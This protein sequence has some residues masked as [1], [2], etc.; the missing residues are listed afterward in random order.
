MSKDSPT[1]YHTRT[2]DL[3]LKS[4]FEGYSALNEAAD[5]MFSAN[6]LENH[7][8]FVPSFIHDIE[9]YLAKAKIAT[10]TSGDLPRREQ[11]NIINTRSQE[12]TRGQKHPKEAI[13]M[14]DFDDWHDCS[15]NGKN[16]NPERRR[17]LAQRFLSW[18]IPTKPREGSAPDAEEHPFRHLNLT[19]SQSSF[20]SSNSSSPM[21][22][23][24]IQSIFNGKMDGEPTRKLM[25]SAMADM[26]IKPRL[27][28][29]QNMG[30]W[31]NSANEA[32]YNKQYVDNFRKYRDKFNDKFTSL[33]INEDRL[34]A[35]IK[36]RKENG[37]Y[38]SDENARNLLVNSQLK[39]HFFQ[40]KIWELRGVPDD[41][42]WDNLY[43]E[44]GR[45]EQENTKRLKAKSESRDSAKYRSGFWMMYFGI[46]LID[47]E[48]KIKFSEW[49]L[50]G[51]GHIDGVNYEM[52]NPRFDDKEI[53]RILGHNARGFLT[54]HT[55]V[56]ANALH[57]IYSG[58]VGT[59]GFNSLPGGT[60]GQTRG[61]Q[62][63][64]R[65]K[66]F[67]QKLLKIGVANENLQDEDVIA[68]IDEAGITREMQND[69]LASLPSST[70]E[71][72]TLLDDIGEGEDTP[73]Y[74]T[75][76][77]EKD[78]KQVMNQF[79]Q[80]YGKKGST[81]DNKEFL[82]N[83]KH[84]YKLKDHFFDPLKGVPE[85]DKTLLYYMSH[86]IANL[87]GAYGE[88]WSHFDDAVNEAF[89]SVFVT[90]EEPMID[91]EMRERVLPS[92]KNTV[93]SLG[94]SY[95]KPTLFQD[96]FQSKPDD[97]AHTNI[98]QDLIAA[99]R[100]AEMS[101]AEQD[102]LL[103]QY[104]EGKSVRVP[105]PQ[106]VGRNPTATQAEDVDEEEYM[107]DKLPEMGLVEYV[108]GYQQTSS[109]VTAGHAGLITPLLSH[110]ENQRNPNH[111]S[112]DY[113]HHWVRDL[114]NENRPSDSILAM[115]HAR[116]ISNTLGGVSK[117][118]AKK[119]ADGGTLRRVGDS[120][121]GRDVRGIERHSPSKGVMGKKKQSVHSSEV[122]K[123]D[124]YNRM[125]MMH[126]LLFQAHH[127]IDNYS[128]EDHSTH[129][130]KQTMPHTVYKTK[131][132]DP[133][134]RGE[135][136][137]EIYQNELLSATK[138]DNPFNAKIAV[139][140]KDE[141]EAAMKRFHED[142]GVLRLPDTLKDNIDSR[143]ELE[144]ELMATN[145]DGGSFHQSSN[146]S[147]VS[148]LGFAERNRLRND[149]MEKPNFTGYYGEGKQY[150][151]APNP[152]SHYQD[153]LSD[154]RRYARIEHKHGR[155]ESAVNFEKLATE[156]ARHV[157]DEVGEM[158][159]ITEDELRKN[160]LDDAQE[161]HAQ[162][163]AA[164]QIM[165]P[166]LKWANPDMFQTHTPK[167]AN[168]A[169]ADTKMLAH[170]CETWM[171]TLNPEERKNWIKNAR[172]Q[173]SRDGGQSE[174]VM[175][176]LKSHFE[177]QDM[178]PAAIESRINRITKDVTMPLQ[179]Q[180]WQG[181]DIRRNIE[182]DDDDKSVMSMMQ[183]YVNGELDSS[184]YPPHE[185]NELVKKIFDEVSRV[186]PK[187]A[188]PQDFAD[189]LHARYIPHRAKGREKDEEGKMIDTGGQNLMQELPIDSVK[190]FGLGDGQ[191]A[192]NYKLAKGGHHHEAELDEYTP[193]MSG[194]EGIKIAGRPKVAGNV[195]Y[196]MYSEIHALNKVYRALL[197]QSKGSANAIEAVPHKTAPLKKDTSDKGFENLTE[198]FGNF[199]ERLKGDVKGVTNEA[200]KINTQFEPV[201]TGGVGVNEIQLPAVHTCPKANRTF[202]HVIRPSRRIATHGLRENRLIVHDDNGDY[203]QGE[204]NMRMRMDPYALREF[205]P[206]L[207]QYDISAD[208][209][210]LYPPVAMQPSGIPGES[211]NSNFPVFN[212]MGS[213]QM[214]NRSD[215]ELLDSLTDDT[216]I[217]KKDGR[218]VPVKSMHRIFDYS[219]LK[220]LRGFSGDWVAS[221]IPKG[222]P[223]IL[224][225]KGKRVKAYNADMKL[226]E[227]TEDID[228]EMSKVNEKDFVVH[229]V[230]DGDMLYFI[231]LLEAADEKTHN[232][233]AKD[234]VRH[235][236]AHFES[237]EH[238]KMPEP[239]NTK[240]AD[241]EGLE[242]AIHLLRE[243]S[244]CDILL[245]DASA[246]YMRGE[247]RHPKWI[248]LSK[249][250]KIDVIILDRKGM[251]YRIGVGPIMHPEHYGSRSVELNGQHYMDVGSAKGPR[252]YDKGEYISVFCTGA[253]KAG[254]ENPTYKLRSARVD[255]DAH[256]QAADS[257]ESLS[258]MCSDSKIPHKVR[259]NKGAI[260]ILFPSLDDEV[261]YKV[262]RE[263]GG[264]MLEPQRTLWGHGEDY[265]IKLSEDMRPHWSPIA[266][267]LL[268]KDQEKAVNTPK[269]YKSKKV[270]PEAPAGHTKERK[271]ILPKEEEIIKQG[272]ELLERGL[273]RLKKEKITYTGVEG[274]GV[275]YA[276]A[277]VESPR[278]PTTNMNDDTLPDFDPASRDYK[279]KPAKTDKKEKVIRTTAGEEA[280]TDN[281]GNITISKPRV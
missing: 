39:N 131:H 173:S 245:R 59:S 55:S 97:P 65:N 141:Y 238:I 13:L 51:A 78:L 103:A 73:N 10:V 80:I 124:A 267:I 115:R 123:D 16:P 95:M 148:E 218:P 277:D 225:K 43:G 192:Y 182:M 49:F 100:R 202:G 170:L 150:I 26:G 130:E 79:A 259:L 15:P 164:S 117:S 102:E 61:Q 154:L 106:G 261:I 54:R 25:D 37:T 138:D 177:N 113:N 200:G 7:G 140:D 90:Q 271:E 205:H 232:M 40:H 203:H 215:I 44:G 235:L 233:P 211:V 156:Q 169:W 109:P 4:Y 42:I 189:V 86:A 91:D 105:F 104:E 186:L 114:E 38:K 108:G 237:S 222:E 134:G 143:R 263:E 262:D 210:T 20:A 162:A 224:Q 223:I 2:I 174:S 219:D 252:G 275:D 101:E 1:Q 160:Y 17:E 112:A 201:G 129:H 8:L 9:N 30:K 57:G 184:H 53:N 71:D 11:A 116:L 136:A 248:L 36:N 163:V 178:K 193:L 199:I 264:W 166:L 183:R 3:F 135:D 21:M 180:T 50:D 181:G 18:D 229:A 31:S 146:G 58:N 99:M 157:V 152:L 247:I 253:T 24:M 52:T 214:L 244:S 45:I 260:H 41:Y 22:V 226:V 168:Q 137:G 98:K 75:A 212:D 32:G 269:R 172:V 197:K 171:R 27:A 158:P 194:G 147:N 151:V 84:I 209:N 29:S 227:L 161:M 118:R 23:Q 145:S 250:K 66:D 213:G 273:E 83:S 234:R 74:H 279:E 56:F 34:K 256:P 217:Y 96:V 85:L 68:L 111:F 126:T 272:L 255:R 70:N 167:L 266:T 208:G 270:D 204:S 76:L 185:K 132:R 188:T 191:R 196:S 228:D 276:D 120:T 179:R 28:Q 107:E 12:V 142:G 268:K 153:A 47:Y 155:T 125:L 48:D 77:D 6:N 5:V 14:F 198:R 122:S 239:Y 254:D 207:P 159:E 64:M 274:L 149:V 241:D 257:V 35:V 195:N 87:Q 46:P 33:T 63:M 176:I 236:R 190:E 175:N 88:E 240:R 69:V 251:N 216:L 139:Y 242:E 110:D 249:E 60:V 144:Q 206:E 128:E 187:N 62:D 92:V 221:H 121:F 19:H 81:A 119:D 127:G 94:S 133:L 281:K 265:F 165:K 82:N 93:D 89:P 72:A 230:I 243:E 67:K 231:D 220:H 278:G 258:L 246:T 280:I